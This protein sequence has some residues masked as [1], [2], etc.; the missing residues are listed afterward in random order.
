MHDRHSSLCLTQVLLPSLCQ[1]GAQLML[2]MGVTKVHQESFLCNLCLQPCKPASS[3]E[4]LIDLLL[5]PV[6]GPHY[7]TLRLAGHLHGRLWQQVPRRVRPRREGRKAQLGSAEGG[8]VFP[9]HRSQAVRPGAHGG[10]VGTPPGHHG[11]HR[12]GL[13]QDRGRLPGHQQPQ[14]CD[15]RPGGEENCRSISLCMATADGSAPSKGECNMNRLHAL[16]LPSWE[17]A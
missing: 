9:G 5:S 3:Q 7:E 15:G 1:A 16:Y 12:L 6:R 17:G 11:A 14:E 10:A 13:K 2:G 8:G 4:F